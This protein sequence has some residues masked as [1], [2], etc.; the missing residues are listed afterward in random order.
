MA[1]RIALDDSWNAV[2]ATVRASAVPLGRSRGVNT[3]A[4]ESVDWTDGAR[5]FTLLA[6]DHGVFTMRLLHERRAVECY[7]EQ[8]NGNAWQR[9]YSIEADG[10]WIGPIASR[11]ASRRLT[12]TTE[13][14]RDIIDGWLTVVVPHL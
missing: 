14:A 4:L 2:V 6:R 7:W 12:T 9:G 5:R 8:E 3:E 13:I 10:S 1:I 11:A